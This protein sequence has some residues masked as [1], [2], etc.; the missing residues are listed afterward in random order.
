MT[1]GDLT[2]DERLAWWQLSRTPTIGP[3]TH[4]KLIERFGSATAALQAL[5]TLARRGG[6]TAPLT[7]FDRGRA[8]DEIAAC[9]K[10]NAH[11]IAR[12]E[13]SYPAYLRQVDDAPPVIILRGRL[14]LLSV[15]IVGIVGARNASLPGRKM[16]YTLAR[17]L[18][19]GGYAVAS[20]LA[21]GID[22]AAHEG[23]L[24][25]GTIAVV[26]GGVDN[27]Y[28]PENAKL[29][30]QILENG[31]IISEHPVGLEPMAAHFPRRNRIISGLALG[32][33]VVEA[34][35]GSGSLIT[36]RAAADQGRDVFAVPGSPLDPRA[37]GPN[38]LIREGAVLVERADHIIQHLTSMRA[39]HLSDRVMPN[40]DTPAPVFD[41]QSL[42]NAR[43]IILEYLTYSPVAI[44]ELVRTCQLHVQL[45]Q[46]AL[47]DL[48]LAERVERLPGNRIVLIEKDFLCE[49]ERSG[50]R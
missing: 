37:G 48:E 2:P 33:C 18:G 7:P 25:T 31:T 17:D 22:T 6:R 8:M 3:I 24:P 19:V 47:L 43:Q 45:V 5:P 29:Y 9:E 35:V 28:P 30:G 15:K 23:S 42:A 14:D 34:T 46:T 10:I 36:A 38:S 1:L 39:T 41:D 4:Q 32:T 50:H 20:G 13:P 11:V 49:S 12:C 21:R 40:Y 26:A 16:A 27:I 44:D